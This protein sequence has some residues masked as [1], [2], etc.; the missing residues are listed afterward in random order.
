M[1]LVPSYR[2]DPAELSSLVHIHVRLRV[3]QCQSCDFVLLQH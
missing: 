2:R 1:E 3:T